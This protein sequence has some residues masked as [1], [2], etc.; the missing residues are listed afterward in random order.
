MIF[1]TSRMRI[2][3]L[4]LFGFVL[5]GAAGCFNPFD[6]DVR[7][8]GFRKAAP[9]PNSPTNLLRLFEWCYV[10]R[11]V[12]E[13]REIFSDDYR[14]VFS[15]VDPAGDAYRDR[16]FTREDE[17]ISTTNLFRGG[18]A[19]QPAATDISLILDNNFAEFTDPRPGKGNFKIHKKIGTSVL[20]S[21][22][23]TDGN[24]T[25]VR[26]RASFFVVRG[27]SAVIPQ[28]L[29]DRGFE[30]DS[31]RWYIERWEDETNTNTPIVIT[32]G[33]RARSAPAARVAPPSLPGR[34]GAQVAR[35]SW[36]ALKAWYQ[37]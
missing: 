9:I 24:Q 4:L 32:D 30:Q 25:E 20:L 28:E 34:N 15:A 12:A 26:G 37:K 22:R 21:I 11:A 23:T 2:L 16:P 31:T 10:N 6:P 1:S 35:I 5:L 7:G 18:D 3:G 36:G 13:Y 29:V 27:D 33:M 14:F 8:T 19:D 17:L